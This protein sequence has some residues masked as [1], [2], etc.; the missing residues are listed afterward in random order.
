MTD[1]IYTD[2]VGGTIESADSCEIVIVGTNGNRYTL[3]PDGDGYGWYGFSL[4]QSLDTAPN[5]TE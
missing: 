5:N 2:L 3:E 4:T 1:D